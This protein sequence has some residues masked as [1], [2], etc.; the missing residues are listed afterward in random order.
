LGSLMKDGVYQRGIAG[1]KH[2]EIH[3]D[4]IRDFLE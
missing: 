4:G 3:L 2:V 1:V